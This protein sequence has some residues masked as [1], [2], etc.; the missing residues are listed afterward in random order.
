M[1][2]NYESLVEFWHL[3][4]RVGILIRVVQLIFNG[5]IMVNIFDVIIVFQRKVNCNWF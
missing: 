5:A 4:P 2:E 1:I 3:T